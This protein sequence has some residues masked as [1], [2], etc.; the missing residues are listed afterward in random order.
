MSELGKEGQKAKKLKKTKQDRNAS[1]PPS[2]I[3]VPASLGCTAAPSPKTKKAAKAAHP[4]TQAS[5]VSTPASEAEAPVASSSSFTPI[6]HPHSFALEGNP[7]TLA[8]GTDIL[9]ELDE[10]SAK[11]RKRANINIT[12]TEVIKVPGTSDLP[13][14]YDGPLHEIIY[15]DK[16]NGTRFKFS[17]LINNLSPA[18]RV[19]N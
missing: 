6:N 15:K 13:E 18:T 12:S 14:N 9:T 16:D 7:A 3:S 11:K 4:L 8:E 19:L 2:N 5:T 10:P 1:T 17:Y